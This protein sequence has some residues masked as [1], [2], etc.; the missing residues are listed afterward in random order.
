MKDIIASYLLSLLVTT[1]A[2]F[3][4]YPQWENYA[5]GDKIKDI[6]ADGNYLWVAT[7]GGLVRIDRTTLEKTFYNKANSG[8]PIN[9]IYCFAIDKQ[10]NIWFGTPEGHIVKFDGISSSTVYDYTNSLLPKG[11]LVSIVIDDS[12]RVWASF[13]E[14]P[15][16]LFF[17]GDQWNTWTRNNTIFNYSPVN[18]F[19]LDKNRTLWVTA[20]RPAK[21]NGTDWEPVERMNHPSRA[22]AVDD[23]DNVWFALLTG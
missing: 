13:L 20:N 8:F 3:A 11:R 17:D 9:Q 22:L 2:L 19:V 21:F 18:K 4:Q 7:Y 15:Y 12:D 1:S 6:K 5:R 14:S 16:L 10:K 23:D